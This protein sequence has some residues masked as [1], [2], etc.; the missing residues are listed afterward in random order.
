MRILTEQSA[1]DLLRWQGVAPQPE[2]EKV[3]SG[4]DFEKPMYEHDFWPDDILYQLIRKPSATLP[5]PGTGNWF[6]LAGIT[7]R[8]V[9]I[10]DGLAGRRA[11]QFKVL[12]P[13]KALEGTAR[14]MAIDL[15]S[16][17]GGVG[18]ATQIYVPRMLL[19]RLQALGPEDRW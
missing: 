6:G 3:L 10:N 14:P 12:M 2:I 11:A 13:F 8:G 5:V 7:T 17:I 9:A 1:A 16:G 15:G 18:G 4:F 19:G